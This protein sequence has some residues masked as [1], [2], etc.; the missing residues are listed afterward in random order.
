MDK[1]R[2]SRKRR[3]TVKTFPVTHEGLEGWVTS[4]RQ[5]DALQDLKRGDIECTPA[6]H[7]A[8]GGASR[9]D[10]AQS[11]AHEQDNTRRCHITGYGNKG[12]RIPY[13]TDGVLTSH[14]YA[15]S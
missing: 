12:R 2:L 9:D 4:N 1:T 5:W 11:E 8:S 10:S 3:F 7:S 14:S 13:S 15:L 6:N